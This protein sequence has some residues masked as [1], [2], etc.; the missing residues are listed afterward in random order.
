MTTKNNLVALR[1]KVNQEI[2]KCVN[3][4]ATNSCSSISLPI[5][6]NLLSCGHTLAGKLSCS[7][8]LSHEVYHNT[9]NPTPTEA[10][11]FWAHANYLFFVPLEEGTNDLRKDYLPWN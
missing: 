4:T 10:K 6:E 5:C 11:K 3:G 2:I 7:M 9:L 8:Y 1:R